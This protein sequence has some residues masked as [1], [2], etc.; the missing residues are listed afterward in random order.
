MQHLTFFT[1]IIAAVFVLAAIGLSSP[2]YLGYA[3]VAVMP[4]ATAFLF[5]TMLS[6]TAKGAA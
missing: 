6:S 1:L 4:L 5:K 2:I 3:V